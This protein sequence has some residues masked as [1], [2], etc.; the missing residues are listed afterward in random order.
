[1]ELTDLTVDIRAATAADAEEIVKL[2]KLAFRG[3]GLLYHDFTLPPLVQTLEELA[4]DFKTHVFLKAVHRE[5][6]IGAVRGRADGHTAH[7][8]RLIVHPEYQNRGIGK[9]LMTAIENRFNDV[10]RYELFTGHLSAKNLALYEKIGYRK[11]AEKPQSDKVMLI[12][13]EKM[14][15]QS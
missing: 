12:C 8:S 3:Q 9:R 11:F 10:R 4:C 1:M 6:I 14:R 2:Q 7:I 5:N 13:M 15:A